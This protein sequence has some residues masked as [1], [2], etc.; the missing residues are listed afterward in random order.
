MD[1]ALRCSTWTIAS[2]SV[3]GLY[4]Q[5]Y[6]GYPHLCMGSIGFITPKKRV[7]MEPLRLW[8]WAYHIQVR[9]RMFLQC[10]RCIVLYLYLG[11]LFNCTQSKTASSGWWYLVKSTPTT[12]ANLGSLTKPGV[13]L[14]LLPA[15]TSSPCSQLCLACEF[16]NLKRFAATPTILPK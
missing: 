11:W 16:D 7:K 1:M 8:V 2:H 9:Q 14:L 15:Q 5:L 10:P 12:V 6:M 3:S 13:D 4:P